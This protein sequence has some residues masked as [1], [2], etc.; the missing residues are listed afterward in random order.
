MLKQYKLRFYNFRLV[1]LLAFTSFFGTQLVGIARSDLYTKQ[2][3]GVVAGFVIMLVLS[4]IDYSWILN[5]QW[6]M[7]AG[8]LGLLLLVILMG[9]SAKGAT[10][11]LNL[12]F[13][14]FQP[15]EL[16]K[17]IIILF[18]AKFFMDHEEDL[19]T[20]HTLVKSAVLIALHL[21]LILIQPDLKNTITSAD[22]FDKSFFAHKEKKDIESGT[23]KKP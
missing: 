18:F 23:Y 2:I 16:A 22:L 15:T 6:I 8:N 14:Q 9:S 3:M 12:G 11:W 4:L 10:R 13:I 19:N 21:V 5:F 1:L 20:L 17:I 7:Y